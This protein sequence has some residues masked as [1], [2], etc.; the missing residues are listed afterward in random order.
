MSR[1][2]AFALLTLA[3]VSGGLACG[4]HAVNCP[5]QSSPTCP[6]LEPDFQTQVDPIFQAVCVTCHGPGGVESNLPLTSYAEITSSRVKLTAFSLILGC[7]MP[8]SN[9]PTPLTE[10]DRQT[11]LA[12]FACGTPDAGTP[13]AAPRDGGATDGDAS[14]GTAPDR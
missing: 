9:A 6:A 1:P 2:V 7:Q 10:T 4:S 13:D 14:D 11:L 12:W 3:S 5:N 8:P